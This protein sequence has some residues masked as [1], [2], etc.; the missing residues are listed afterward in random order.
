M[1]NTRLI[2]NENV[3]LCETY[4]TDGYKLLQRETNFVYG[5][6]VVD[7]IEGYDSN[8]EPYSRFTYVETDELVQEEGDTD[9]N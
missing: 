3:N 6:S 2:N 7:V 8:G 1:V 9:G 4:S 5:S